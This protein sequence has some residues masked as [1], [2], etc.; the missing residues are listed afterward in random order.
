MKFR[1]RGGLF[2]VPFLISYD[3]LHFFTQRF[4]F[5]FA[6]FVEIIKQHKKA[7]RTFYVIS[8]YCHNQD[9]GSNFHSFRSPSAPPVTI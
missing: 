6:G 9:F 1:F 7:M 2:V 4:D 5:L 3:F 8:Y